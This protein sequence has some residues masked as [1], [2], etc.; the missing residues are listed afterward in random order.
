VIA[1]IRGTV[2][3]VEEGA[4]IVD[5]H[6]FLM[7][8]FSSTHTLAT[9]EEGDTV[10]LVTHL[11]VRE[12]ALTLYGFSTQPELQLFQLLL[13]VNGVGP[14]VA[15]SLLSFD[16]P[17]ALYE[18]ISNE[19]TALLSRVP[20]VGKVTA[21]RIVFD[22]KRKLPDTIPGAGQDIDMT[23]RDAIDA[24]EALGYTTAEARAGLAAVEKRSGMTV[25]ERV[26]AAL[27]QMSSG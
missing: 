14:R 27:Q 24:L 3:G 16:Q 13:G 23:D 22:L 8:V 1:G 25:E 5:L 12:D 17:S 7:R 15:L 10:Q 26:Y 20:G 21:G 9:V 4:L 18:A 6:G 19:D 11:V 2:A